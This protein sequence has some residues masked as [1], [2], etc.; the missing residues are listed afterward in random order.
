MKEEMDQLV[1]AGKIQPKHVA[2]LTA[3]LESGFGQ[4]R[5]WGFGKIRALDGIAGRL[6]ID[7]PG[8]AGH[9]LDLAF[10]ADSLPLYLYVSRVCL[11]FLFMKS[12]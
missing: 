10:A 11:F 1:A 4:H 2:P 7:F 3:L 12:K 5:S 9:T 8:K 6:V